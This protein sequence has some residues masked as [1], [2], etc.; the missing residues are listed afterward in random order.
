MYTVVCICGVLS[1]NIVYINI[2]IY[3]EKPIH[4]FYVQARVLKCI[5]TIHK[6]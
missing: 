6:G 5:L 1:R 3:R 2:I 4:I